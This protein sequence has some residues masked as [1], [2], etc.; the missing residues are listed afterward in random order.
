MEHARLTSHGGL[1]VRSIFMLV[2]AVLVTVFLWALLI[3]PPAHAADP[4]HWKGDAVV[5]LDNIYNGPVDEATAQEFGLKKTDQVYVFVDPA[6]D[7]TNTSSNS[8]PPEARKIRVIYFGD[9]DINTATQAKYVDYDYKSRGNYSNPSSTTTLTL[10]AKSVTNDGATSCDIEDGL[11]WIICPVTNTLATAMD[12]IYDILTGFL[13][14]RPV[15]T[16]QDNALYRAWKFMQAFANVAFV[17]AFLVIIYSQITS[18]GISNYGIKKLLPRL[19]IAALLVNISY[20]ICSVAIDISNVLGYSLQDIFVSM[21]NSLVGGEGNS[22]D[23]AALLDWRSLTGAALSGGTIGIAG[24]ASLFIAVSDFGPLVIFLLLPALIIA[25]LSVLVALVVLAAR[26]AIIIVL[27]ILSPLAFVAY[28]LPNTEKWFEKWRDT[29][30]TMLFV[31]PAFSVIFG[32]SQ[33]AATAIIQTADSINLIILGMLVQVA[34]LIITPILIRVG[35]GILATIAG[36]VNNPKT[37]IIDRT[38]TWSTERAEDHKARRLS[39]KANPLL[40]PLKWSAQRRDRT[41]RKREGWRAAHTSMADARWANDR[42]FSKIDQATR[43]AADSKTLGEARSENRYNQSKLVNRSRTQMLDID[44][45]NAQQQVANSAEQVKVQYANLKVPYDATHNRIP[46]HLARRASLARMG[47]QE[48][49]I[50]ARQLHNAESM[51]QQDYA[52]ALASIAEL[53]QRAKGVNP[54]GADEALASAVATIREAYGKNVEEA[55]QI[56]KH[57]ELSS[58]ERQDHAEG[59]SFNKSVEF[60]GL[61]I[62]RDFTPHNTFTLE[63]ALEDQLMRGTADEVERLVKLS[64]TPEYAGYRSTFADAL[65]KSPGQLAKLFHVSGQA[66]DD[67]AQGRVAGDEGL[68]WLTARSLAR[69]KLSEADISNLDATTVARYLK[70]VTSRTAGRAGL[71]PTE[72][73]ILDTRIAEFSKTVR[74]TFLGDESSNIKD[75]AVEDLVKIARLTDP[76]FRP[77]QP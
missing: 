13:A 4:A 41:R 8:S 40:Q 42:G 21:R 72:Q 56:N 67:I 48:A 3:S 36:F 60:D 2:I 5:Y 44:L 26:Q 35:G 18:V 19:I 11:G 65:G 25:V 39:K 24:G 54:H 51:Q 17:I 28:L 69:G 70:V 55:R 7:S 62:D 49:G 12:S 33:L 6:R 76:N 61:T 31:F 52:K 22:W 10:E 32:G 74:K 30:I 37:G 46:Q 68:D 9:V 50:I 59:L 1:S 58:K 71:S 20:F 57:F 47:A 53:R 29:F 38:R 75:V 77:P 23:E 45:Q 66:L 34:P 43:E 64:G 14:V 27:V 63:A 15:E 73:A 16:G